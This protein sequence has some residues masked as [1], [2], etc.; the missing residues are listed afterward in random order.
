MT[1]SAISSPSPMV[2]PPFPMPTTLWGSSPA[3][4]TRPQ[5]K[6]GSFPMT[7]EEI[8]S[9]ASNMLIPQERWANPSTPSPM[10]MTT[11]S[12]GRT[13][14]PPMAARPAPRCLG[15]VAAIHNSY[16]WYRK[17]IQ[18]LWYLGQ[19]NVF[20]FNQRSSSAYWRTTS[21]LMV[22]FACTILIWMKTM[23]CPY[24]GPYLAAC[25]KLGGK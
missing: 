24:D 1:T 15:Q 22:N 10:A 17:L 7:Q 21:F 19:Q 13:C 20:T 3:R 14:L 5:V 9:P 2:L 18:F 23:C 6:P 12:A 4:T 8:S 25:T 11:P 16:P